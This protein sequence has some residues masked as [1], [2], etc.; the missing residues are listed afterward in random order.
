[1]TAAQLVACERLLDRLAPT[2]LHHGDAIDAD[3]EMHT[4]ARTRGVRIVVHPPSNPA[5]RA[6]CE[7]DEI[8]GVLSYIARNHSIVDVTDLLVATPVGPEASDPRSGTWKTI[9]YARRV[10]KRI[11]IVNPDGDLLESP[12]EPDLFSGSRED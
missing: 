5:C 4:I 6:F 1:M 11:V 12:P 7:G 8:L 2:E 10:G 9:R 3:A